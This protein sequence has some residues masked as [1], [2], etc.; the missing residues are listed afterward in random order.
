MFERRAQY[1]ASWGDVLRGIRR[2]AKL[3]VLNGVQTLLKAGNEAIKDGAKVKEILSSTLKPALG[4]VLG[5]TSEQVANR[6]TFEK[7][8]A[9]PPP[10]PPTE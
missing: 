9:A 7:P 8:T 5:A 4:A 1:G 3:V 2:V 10:S 6:F